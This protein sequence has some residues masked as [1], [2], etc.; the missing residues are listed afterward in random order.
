MRKG[1]LAFLVLSILVVCAIAGGGIAPFI[2][3]RFGD[4]GS[5]GSDVDPEEFNASQRSD[6]ED[7]LRRE[8]AQNPNDVGRISLLAQVLASEGRIAE[9]IPLYEQALTI[10][11]NNV[12]VRLNFGVSLSAAGKPADAEIQFLKILQADPNQPEAHY[13]LAQLYE[14]W[15]PPRTGEAI[16]HYQQVVSL[17]PADTSIAQMAAA[18]LAAIGVGTPVA[19]P[20]VEATAAQEGT[21][22][23]S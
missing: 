14:G 2:A 22:Q 13:Y 3:D 16:A 6:L 11:P 7:D 5:S 4:D 8:I 19:S 1:Q 18:A 12:R 21:P 10:D 9:A 17:Q 23:S 15:D 20:E